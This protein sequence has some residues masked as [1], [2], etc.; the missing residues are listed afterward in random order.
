MSWVRQTWAIAALLPALG[1]GAAPSHAAVGAVSS[2]V[3]ASLISYRLIDLDLNDGV[4]PSILFGEVFQ[5]RSVSGSNLAA[6]YDP[7]GYPV[8]GP[9]GG[10]YQD[11]DHYPSP[12]PGTVAGSLS[13]ASS[14]ATNGLQ[15][16]WG[17]S[18][19]AAGQTSG[20]DARGLDPMQVSLYS[21][22]YYSGQAVGRLAFSLSANT[23]ALFS[24]DGAAFT[25]AEPTS[26]GQGNGGVDLGVYL[27]DT[28]S[29]WRSGQM[30]GP[31]S[32]SVRLGAYNRTAAA[33]SG[34]LSMTADVLG[35]VYGA[36]PV[37]EVQTWGLGLVGVAV[38]MGARRRVA[39]C[40][41]PAKSQGQGEVR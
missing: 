19:A 16:V 21:S 4:T 39:V 5:A 17:L 3:Q 18:V 7:S 33:Q 23:V 36:A 31:G 8:F 1:L 24:F 40:P 14:S 26:H 25:M 2:S 41:A 15:G 9:H 11:H 6:V 29:T 28:S 37:P 38:V 20:Y 22:G 35:M 10:T 32:F 12:V 34:H 13:T 30:D 27:G